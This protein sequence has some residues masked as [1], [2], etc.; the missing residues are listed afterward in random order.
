MLALLEAAREAAIAN[1]GLGEYVRRIRD[2]RSELRAQVQ[3]A[4]QRQL[5]SDIVSVERERDLDVRRANITRRREVESVRGRV[6]ALA[7]GIPSL[8]LTI[9]AMS[10]WTRR[11]R[12]ELLRIPD[13][14]QKGVS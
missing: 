5:D 11:R 2:Q 1:R 3:R 4:A 13:A 7:L 12:D 9:I 14:R 8:I 6:R 10:V